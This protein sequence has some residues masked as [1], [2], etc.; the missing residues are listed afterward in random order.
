MLNVLCI[1]MHEFIY[2]YIHI[3]LCLFIYMYVYVCGVYV[4]VA[5]FQPL[6]QWLEGISKQRLVQLLQ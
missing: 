3:Y 2:I 6:P 4:C 5:C 1:F